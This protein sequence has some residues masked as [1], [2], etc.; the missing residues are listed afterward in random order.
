MMAAALAEGVTV[1]SNVAREPE[2]VDLA[3]FLIASGAQIEGAGTSRLVVHGRKQLHGTEYTIMPDRI[4]AGTLMVAAAITRSCVSLS[5]VV[6]HH[7]TSAMEKLSSA[8]CKIE[9]TYDALPEAVGGRGLRGLNLKT[10]PFPGFPTDLQ[11]QFMSL[12]TTC[13]GAS[14][15]EESIF[16]RR[17]RQG[18]LYDT[19][20]F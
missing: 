18:M 17:M 9:Q 7:L 5:P 12:L 13:H 19:A 16:E 2:V 3:N 11:P 6:P 14:N 4:E 10:S 15:V 20:N 8:G 1:L